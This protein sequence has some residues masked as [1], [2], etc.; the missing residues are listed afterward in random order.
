MTS[1]SGDIVSAARSLAALQGYVQHDGRPYV[2]YPPLL[3]TI[4]APIKLIG[5]DPV[6]SVRFLNAFCFGLIIFV[7]GRWLCRSIDSLALALLGTAAV[8]LSLPLISVTN[9]AWSDPIFAL[10]L[11]L[12]VFEIEKYLENGEAASFYLSICYAALCCLARYIGVSAILTGMILL[13]IGRKDALRTR[14]KRVLV[15]GF[16]AALP[17]LVWLL[18]NYSITAGATGERGASEITFAK[19]V[20]YAASILSGWFLPGQ[21]PVAPRII[22]LGL[23]LAGMAAWLI[24]SAGSSRQ[25]ETA[26]AKIQKVLPSFALV[27]VYALTL[28]IVASIVAL[29]RLSSR[30]LAPIYVPVFL[31]LV[32]IVDDVRQ[33]AI[34]VFFRKAVN[35]VFVGAFLLWL[36]FPLRYVTRDVR[37]FARNGA[38]GYSSVQWR[39]SDLIRYL[40]QQPLDGRVYS[41]EPYA[42]HILTGLPAAL[43]PRKHLFNAPKSRTEDLAL[44]TEA[45]A[46]GRETR[47]VWF[48]N[49]D[50]PYL[51]DIDELG[52]SFTVEVLEKRLDGSVYLIK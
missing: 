44:F 26:G 51:Y 14:F 23:I 19:N 45:L 10:F 18:R 5:I 52:E 42:V 8:V 12:F 30:F 1:I 22:V 20:Y 7:A 46:S 43:S 9:Y 41:N 29:D 36:L 24:R 3:P 39:S 47:L 4:L 27:V 40:E 31:L 16:L 50:R 15:F 28:L 25:D 6:H 13:I 2:E 37:H 11:L 35:V 49:V 48:A 33:A 17:T 38:G 21:I 32:F 34:R